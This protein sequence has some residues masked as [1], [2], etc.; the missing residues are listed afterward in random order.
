MNLKEIVGST[1]AYNF[2]AHTQ[3]C[4]GHDSLEA[5]ARAAARAG[6]EHFGF[7]PHSP[8]PID[9][10]C[11]MSEADL[12]T[13]FD[14]IE[15]IRNEFSGIMHIYR[16]VEIDYLGDEWGPSSPLFQSG[17]FDF[18]IGS[19]HFIPSQEGTFVDIDGRYEHFRER[20]ERFFHGDIRY[21]AR[22]F[23][24]R[25]HA[26]LDAGGFDIIGHFDK[27][28]QNA[29]FF[30]PGIED[31]PWYRAIV[32]DYI[33]HIISSGII[34]EINT[35]ARLQHGRFFPSERHWRRLINAGITLMVNSDAH[36]ADRIAASRAEAFEILDTII[37]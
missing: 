1:R 15:Q 2:H 10:P 16:G 8:I 32:D 12:P 22:T 18:S 30:L 34:V 27:I 20:M 25:S 33:D 6:F 29:S 28:G 21:V 9:S 24:E 13:Y 23:Y 4:D 37:K 5:I 3:F 35:K 11:N 14:A 26:M 36:Y 19:V 17:L 31:M 7:S